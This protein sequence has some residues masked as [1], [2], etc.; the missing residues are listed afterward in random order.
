[1]A[2][3]SPE[4][5]AAEL[6]S[7]ESEQTQYFNFVYAAGAAEHGT[8]NLSKTKIL[9]VDGQEHLECAQT[10]KQHCPLFADKPYQRFRSRP[11]SASDGC[12]A[13]HRAGCCGNGIGSVLLPPTFLD[14]PYMEPRFVHLRIQ[15][16]RTKRS[17]R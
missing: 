14:Q 2:Q 7:T 11:A 8:S 13:W 17:R 12:A 3:P 5:I 16:K 9:I 1:M 6:P 15:K 10:Q 4:I